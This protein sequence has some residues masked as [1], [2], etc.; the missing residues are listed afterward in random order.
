MENIVSDIL[1]E[2]KK[3]GQVLEKA[4]ADAASIKREAE[5]KVAK[6]IADAH[7]KA[8]NIIKKAITDT[9]IEAED[10]R[11]KALKQKEEEENNLLNGEKKH[12]D[13]L[14]DDI[15]TLIIRTEYE[16]K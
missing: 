5:D 14:V 10:M 7:I 16:G 15:V 9:Q 1:E 11:K 3:V 13:K 6:I 4:R 12:T 2:E 8:Q